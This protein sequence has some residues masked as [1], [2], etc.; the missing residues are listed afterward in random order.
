[1]TRKVILDQG[2][3]KTLVGHVA[4]PDEIA[5]AVSTRSSVVICDI[6]L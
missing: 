3:E 6:G 2:R 5:D 4:K 1:V